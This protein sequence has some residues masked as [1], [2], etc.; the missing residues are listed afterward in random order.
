MDGAEDVILAGIRRWEEQ[1]DEGMVFSDLKALKV[2]MNQD[3][4]AVNKYMLL[5][6][7]LASK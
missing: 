6:D 7:A 1:L 5:L 2:A 4:K 3:V